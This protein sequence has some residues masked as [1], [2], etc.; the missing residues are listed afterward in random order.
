MRW[1][2]KSIFHNL[3]QNITLIIQAIGLSHRAVEG[4]KYC[5]LI[6]KPGLNYLRSKVKSA[7]HLIYFLLPIPRS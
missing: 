6:T 2:Q 7:T 5:M 3:R 4:Q 1:R